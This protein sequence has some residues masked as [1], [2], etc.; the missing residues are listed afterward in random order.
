MMRTCLRLCTGLVLFAL[1][2]LQGCASVSRVATDPRDPW[3]KTN[4]QIYAFNDALD[5]MIARPV[6]KTYVEVVPQPLRT[7]AGHFL[8]NLRDVWTLANTA[9][10]GKV[11]MTAETLMRIQVNTFFGL[12]GLLDVAS[13]M[14]IPHHREDFGQTLAV[15]GMPSGPYVMLPLLGPSTLRDALAQGVDLNV[16]VPGMVW[17]SST[18]RALGVLRVVDTRASLLMTVDAMRNAALDPYTFVRDAYLQKR[19]NDV[20]DG[21]P[22]SN[23]DFTDPDSP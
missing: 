23:F 16:D 4:R 14:R 2:L 19:R 18:S 21:N 6:A 3:E 7:G 20:Y 1:F 10:Q 15:W 12:G 8:A 17:D 9:L 22:P 11:Q 13:E 5:V